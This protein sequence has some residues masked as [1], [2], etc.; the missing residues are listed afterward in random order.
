M[1]VTVLVW[2]REKWNVI[3]VVIREGSQVKE[4]AS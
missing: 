4:N 3:I 1:G 2:E